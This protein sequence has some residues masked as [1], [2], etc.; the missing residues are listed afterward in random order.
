MSLKNMDIGAVMR[1]LAERR[2]EEAMREGKFDNLRGKGEP[3]EL[4]EMPPEESARMTWWMLRI[5]KNADFVPD[6]VRWRKAIDGLRADL[7]A[8]TD[9]RRV[10]QLVKA[11]NHLVQRINTLGTN[12]L[13][14][15]VAAVHLEAELGRARDASE[16]Q[17]K[18]TAGQ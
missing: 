16:A 13:S 17:R 4:D 2:I 1:S 8:T 9:E 12:A 14:T 6:E 3:L 10:R 15:P 7:A 5:L 11:I 18:R